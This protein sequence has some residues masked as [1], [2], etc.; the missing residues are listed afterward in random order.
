MYDLRGSRAVNGVDKK[1]NVPVR[2]AYKHFF[3]RKRQ[4]LLFYT[5]L[6][7]GTATGDGDAETSGKHL[8]RA[9]DKSI[10]R[11][12]ERFPLPG[13]R[14]CVDFCDCVRSFVLAC[15]TV[16]THTHTH[17]HTH[18]YSTPSAP[19]DPPRTK[20]TSPSHPHSNPRRPPLSSECQTL[21]TPGISMCSR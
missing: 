2:P 4:Q 8:K 19:C 7:C 16:H 17:T 3:S 15:N 14:F 6:A 12:S 18:I 5:P 20:T 9:A 11:E 21:H 13:K 1:K 10:H